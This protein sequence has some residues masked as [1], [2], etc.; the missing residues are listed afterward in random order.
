MQEYVITDGGKAILKAE[1][2]RLKEL[3]SNGIRIMEEQI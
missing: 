2:A 3:V 1:I